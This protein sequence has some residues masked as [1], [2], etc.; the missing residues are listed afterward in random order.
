MMLRG[1]DTAG[2]LAATAFGLALTLGLSG[3]PED[4]PAPATILPATVVDAATAD[5]SFTTLLTALD[6][7][8]LTTTLQGEGPFTVF[9]PTDAAFEALPDG[10]LDALLADIPALTDVLTYHVVAG[11]HKAE[12]VTMM[13]SFTTLQGQDIAISVD[14]GT[15]TINGSATVTMTDIETQNGVIHVI[16]AVLTPEEDTPAPSIVDIATGDANFSTLVSA[17]TAADLVTTLQGEGPFTVFA[18]TNAAFDALPAGTLDALLA[19]IP[20]LTNILTYHVAA[21]NYDADAVTA[22]TELEMLN[23]ADAA[24]SVDGGTV[25]IA[26]AVVSMTNIAASN[27]V[28]HVIDA[29]ML[30]PEE[31]AKPSIV[32]IATGDANFSTLVTALTAADLVTTLQ[33]EG[34][35]TVFAPTNAAFDALPAGTLDALLADIPALTEILTYHVASG[36]YDA[37]AV[38]ALS[39]LMMLSGDNAAITVDNGMVMIAGATISMTNIEASNGI[40]HVLDAVMLPPEKPSIVDIA[41][42]DAN[43]STL[44]TALTAADLVTTLQGEGPFTVFAPTNAAFDALPAGTLDAL[45]ADIP[46]LTNILTY[47]VA[48][49]SYDADAVTALTELM[50]LNGDDAAITVDNGMVMIAGATISMTNIEASNGMVHVLDAVMLPPEAP[51]IVDIAT[52]DDN[53]STLVAALTAADLVTTLQGDGPFTVFAPTNAAF[54]ALPAGTVDALLNDIP[55]L[56][57]ILTYHVVS[58]TVDS[59]QALASVLATTLQGSDVKVTSDG[60]DVFIN[61][62]KVTMANIEASNGMVHVIDAVLLPPGN[63]VDIAVADPQFSTL[64]AAVTA[65]D[66]VDTLSGAGPFTVFA[67]TD[68]AFAALPPGTVDSLLNDIPAL[69]DILTYHVVPGRYPASEVLANSSLATVQGTSF[70]ITSDANG[71]YVD[72]AQIIVTDIPASNGIIHVIDAVILP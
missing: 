12:H 45:L 31:P 57:D 7:A 44:V 39:E 5:G 21:G 15:V 67:P 32:E 18:P 54:D 71:A 29:V 33:G 28:V 22:L 40:V 41:T 10:T 53:F 25:T 8:D 23:G 11:L 14:N 19:D 62:A 13:P 6:A 42:G 52:G 17:L 4:D 49:G 3:C 9:A 26:G 48:S 2:K 70:D 37:D 30:P 63:I 72:G 50:M 16:D 66:L 47:H 20:A 35:F 56:T 36:T 51:S 59:A 69:T 55:T 1:F 68:A 46:A 58:G 60:T 65:A 38:S 24:I 34:P 61:N 64:V 43:F 27:G